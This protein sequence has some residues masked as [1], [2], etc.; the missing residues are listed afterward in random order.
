MAPSLRTSTAAV[1]VA[2]VLTAS[3]CG[4]GRGGPAIVFSATPAGSAVEQ[5]FG[6]Q[7]SGSGLEQLTTGGQPAIDPAFSA[8]SKR[9]AFARS[10]VGIFTMNP[11]GT[12]R[13]RVTTGSRDSYPAWSPD[14]KKLAFVRPIGPKWRLYVVPVAGGTTPTQ[15]SLATPAGRPS[16]TTAGLLIPSG[17]D[18]VRVDPTTGRVLKYYGANVDA[19]WGL[20]SVALSPSV[21]MLTYMGARTPEPGDMECAEG[22]CQ[23]YG[24]FIEILTGK[25]TP[26]LIVKNAGPATFSPDGKQIVF[27]SGGKLEIRS[28]SGGAPKTLSTGKAY[29]TDTAPPAWR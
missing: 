4:G 17:G 3:A 28:V 12:G 21:S 27:A 6:I 8:D 18:L 13:H 15:L 7:P 26:R 25:K 9:L 5:L 24:L 2:L 16:W 20:D 19:I 22:P 11:D 14:G 1:A 23:R 10:G 29:P